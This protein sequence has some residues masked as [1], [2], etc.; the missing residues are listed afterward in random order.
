LSLSITFPRYG[1]VN[2]SALTIFAP[3]SVQAAIVKQG[4]DVVAHWGQMRMLVSVEYPFKFSSAAM[5]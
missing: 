3:I 4:F 2:T 1:V 5:V